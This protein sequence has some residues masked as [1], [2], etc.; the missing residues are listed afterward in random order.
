MILLSELNLRQKRKPNHKILSL[1]ASEVERLSGQAST[2]KFV[3]KE[4]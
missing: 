2:I 3:D 1:H 4:Y